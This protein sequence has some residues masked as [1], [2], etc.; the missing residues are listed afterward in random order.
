MEAMK[1]LVQHEGLPNLGID[2]TLK[3]LRCA[4]CLS[5]GHAGR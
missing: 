2:R 3:Q 5:A 1:P 4:C